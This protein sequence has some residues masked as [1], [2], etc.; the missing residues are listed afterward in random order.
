MMGYRVE[1]NTRREKIFALV[2]LFFKYTGEVKDLHLQLVKVVDIDFLL[3][4]VP[5]LV[6]RLN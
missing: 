5:R 6:A 4:F 1:L 3:Y 2:E